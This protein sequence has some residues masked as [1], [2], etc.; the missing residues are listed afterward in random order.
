MKLGAVIILSFAIS[1][2]LIMMGTYL[3]ISHATG[4]N[5]LLMIGLIGAAVFAACAVYEVRVSKNIDHFKKTV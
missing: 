3:K 2:L 5:G 1:F 4:A